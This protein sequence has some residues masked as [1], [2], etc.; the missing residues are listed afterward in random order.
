MLKPELAA[1]IAEGAGLGRDKAHEVL[2][3]IADEITAAL[4]RGHEV[5]LSGFGSFVI[6]ERAARGGKNPRT[7]ERIEIPASRSVAFRPGKALR[8]AL[9]D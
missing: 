9:R 2:T 7:G 4:T 5:H 6:R 1:H 3:A 8:D